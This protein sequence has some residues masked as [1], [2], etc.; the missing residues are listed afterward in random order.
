L[1]KELGITPPICASCAKSKATWASF[2]ASKSGHA[3]HVLGLV[4]CDLWGL[5]PAQTI[6]GTWYVITFT[7]DKS[8][9]VWV[10]FLK[11]KSNAFAALKEWLTFVEKETGCKL[12]IFHTDNGGEFL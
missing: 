4:H 3:E 7:N 9:L 10:S 1:K 5:A 2:P 12:L 6:N 11:C 8:H